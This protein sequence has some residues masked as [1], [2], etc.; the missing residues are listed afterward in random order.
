MNDERC[1]IFPNQTGEFVPP[2]A[3][4]TPQMAALTAAAAAQHAAVTG[5]HGHGNS[6]G[7]S[8]GKDGTT[9]SCRYYAEGGT[10]PYGDTWYVHYCHYYYYYFVRYRYISL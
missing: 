4:L 10:C 3:A 2:L 9:T 6:V 5:G 1:M 8:G 7:V